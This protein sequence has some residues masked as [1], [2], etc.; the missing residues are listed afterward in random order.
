M[1]HL[2]FKNDEK[3]STTNQDVEIFQIIQNIFF[4]YLRTIIP[5]IVKLSLLFLKYEYF[6]VV[7]YFIKANKSFPL[8]LEQEQQCPVDYFKINLEKR[9]VKC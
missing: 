3:V 6:L 5:V 8:L 2:I 1:F 7:E 4:L 9:I